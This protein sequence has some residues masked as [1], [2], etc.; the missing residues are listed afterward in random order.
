MLRFQGSLPLHQTLFHQL[1]HTNA[2]TANQIC[3]STRR[4]YKA[5]VFI[6][7]STIHHNTLAALGWNFLLARDLF[8]EAAEIQ[9]F[10]CSSVC[11]LVQNNSVYK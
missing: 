9:R 10:F 7:D 5:L 1:A 4:Y 8:Y 3:S 11:H 6:Q 2:I